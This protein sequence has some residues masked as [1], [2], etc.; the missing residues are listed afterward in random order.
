[1]KKKKTVVQTEVQPEVKAEVKAEVQK[2]VPKTEHRKCL[3]CKHII[4]IG[5]CMCCNYTGYAERLPNPFEA[6]D[7][8]P[9]DKKEETQND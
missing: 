9:L 1:M 3:K 4:M 6:P 7:W 5:N 2:P 8:C